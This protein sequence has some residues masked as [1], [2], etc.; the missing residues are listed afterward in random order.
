MWGFFKVI[1]PILDPLTRP[2]LKFNENLRDFIPPAQLVSDHGGDADFKYDH[3]VYWPALCKLAEE[4]Q[5]AY[6]E[7]WVRGGRRIGESENYLKGGS[8]PSLTEMEEA[9]EGDAAK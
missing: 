5:K 6:E 1:T 8:S 9:E 3:K 4:R 7:R 2:K